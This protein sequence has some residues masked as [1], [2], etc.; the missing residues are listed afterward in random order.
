MKIAAGLLLTS[1]FICFASGELRLDEPLFI[2]GG[3]DDMLQY[4][5]GSAHW[6]TWEGHYRGVWFDTQDFVP[7]SMGID[8]GT[9]EYWFYHHSSYPWDTSAFY[10]ELWN[11]NSSGPVTFLDRTEATAT[12]Y[13]AVCVNYP[14][15]I[16]CDRNFWALMET[17]MSV[18]GWPS[19]LGDNTPNTVDHS[20]FLNDEFVWEPWV[21]TGSVASDYFIR[22]KD[23]PFMLGS[24]SWGAIKGLYR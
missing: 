18:G 21:M 8:L 22:V 19:L 14:T 16:I 11:G 10:T 7:G 12:H 13:S 3:T 4:D 20:F 23:A 24:E 6:L 17:E 5:D 9:S 15:P 1:V 2:E